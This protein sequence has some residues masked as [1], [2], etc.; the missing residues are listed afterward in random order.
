MIVYDIVNIK[1]LSVWRI[2]HSASAVNPRRNGNRTR[3][4]IDEKFCIVKA[5]SV[6]DG[7][8]F[9]SFLKY[10][11]TYALRY[12]MLIFSRSAKPHHRKYGSMHSPAARRT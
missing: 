7:A 8:L 5:L 3:P 2:G 12:A 9:S 1:F 4:N 11:A 6:S 10:S